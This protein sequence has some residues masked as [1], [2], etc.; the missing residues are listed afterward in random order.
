MGLWARAVRGVLAAGVAGAVVVPLAGAAGA[1][2]PAPLP[3]RLPAATGELAEPYGAQRGAVRR[4]ARVAERY[5]NHERAEALRALAAPGRRLLA[6]DGRGDGRVVE[7]FGDLGSAERVA[8]LVPGSDTRI[9][10][11]DPSEGTDNPAKALAG[12]AR[13]LH[14]VL[15]EGRTTVVAW[16]GY[17]AP[18]TM[19]TAVLGTGRAD[20]GA[21][22]L[23]E[24]LRWVHRARPGV[25]VALLCHS[26]GAVVCGRAAG[27]L[28][29]VTDIA[30]YGAPGTGVGSAEGLGADARVWV[31]RGAGDWIA[32][33]PHVRADLM[34]TGLGLGP[35][36]MAPEYG[37]EDF[38]AGQ[39]GHSD[40]L[41]PGSV[42]LR[43]LAAIAEGAGR[44]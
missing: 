44:G 37:A 30:F 38:P 16:L 4:A 2:T 41:R 29:G 15:G 21:A 42:S 34:D 28:D 22:R 26:Y 7:V 8:V 10:T 31:G 35:D 13:A 6:F 18:A 3:V 23:R 12:A 5:G 11:Y 43:S 19:G 33:V 27:Q 24:F 25:G 32:N 20:E 14:G 39:G 36:P 40:Y 1:V 17:D 9:E